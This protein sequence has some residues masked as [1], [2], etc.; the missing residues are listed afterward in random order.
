MGAVNFKPGRTFGAGDT[1]TVNL[2]GMNSKGG[3]SSRQYTVKQPIQP[4]TNIWSVSDG[5]TKEPHGT[6]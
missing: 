4:N 6:A 3:C 2:S 5:V 1:V